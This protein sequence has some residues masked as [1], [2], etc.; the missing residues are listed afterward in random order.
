VGGEDSMLV[1]ASG[2]SM[3]R[4]MDGGASIRRSSCSPNEPRL[5]PAFKRA[6]K[7][8]DVRERGCQINDPQGQVP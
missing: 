1:P 4:S 6:M 3:L 2:V 7:E 5:P 8:R